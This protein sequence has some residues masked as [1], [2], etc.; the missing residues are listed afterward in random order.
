MEMAAVELGR[1]LRDRGHCITYLTNRNSPA[2]RAVEASKL[3]LLPF[4]I[5]GYIDPLSVK[6][7]REWV[8]REDVDLV[9][10]HYSKD[11][12]ALATALSMGRSQI[13]LVLTKHIG[14]MR[15]KRDFFHR[16]IY[17]R[18][19]AVVAI[20][21]LIRQ[22]VIHTHPV[23]P[24]KVR[25]IPNGV[26][27]RRFGL[28]DVDCKAVRELLGIPRDAIVVGMA[29]RLSW[30]KGYREFLEMAQ[31]LIRAR[32]DVFFLAVGG[33]TVGEEKEAEAV[34]DF[35]RSLHLDGR[36]VFTGFREDVNRLYGAMDVF[37]YPAYAEAFGLV[38]IEA[39]ASGLPVV[40]SNSDGVPEIVVDGKTGRLVRPR[41]SDALTATVLELLEDS[42]TLKE[43][44]RAGRQRV[45][46]LY[47]I[48]KVVDQ[49]EILYGELIKEK[50]G[51]DARSMG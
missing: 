25:T 7:I 35:A 33:S 43:Y 28:K 2:G 6:R 44:G 49:I 30:W 8:K 22:N 47:D 40:S 3:P 26:D 50:G 41:D 38:L 48:Q 34:L 15:P 9:H 37:V 31:R 24:E 20:S 23:P 10:T 16:W 14:T 13:P 19:D 36:I 11:L 46:E 5:R 42:D 18:V 17:R 29:G 45:S 51:N 12:W 27:L 21:E 4:S 1:Q 32:S 39:M